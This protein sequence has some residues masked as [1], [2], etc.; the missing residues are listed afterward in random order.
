[1]I[2]GIPSI[3][4]SSKLLL[5]TV[6]RSMIFGTLMS[7]FPLGIEITWY[8]KVYWRLISILGQISGKLLIR[9]NKGSLRLYSTSTNTFEVLILPFILSAGICSA[10]QLDPTW[11]VTTLCF[12]R[13]EAKQECTLKITY[14]LQGGTFILK[15]TGNQDDFVFGV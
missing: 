9:V 8:F 10:S 13:L 7:T 3:S 2:S 12:S 1:M 5:I 6:L 11:G 4:C 14:S 15:M